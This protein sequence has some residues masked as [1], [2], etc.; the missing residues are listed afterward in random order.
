MTMK[1][2]GNNL[3]SRLKKVK[4]AATTGSAAAYI[5]QYGLYTNPAASNLVKR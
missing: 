1:R 5:E 2:A 4:H 3:S